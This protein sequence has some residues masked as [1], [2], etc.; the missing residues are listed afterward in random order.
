[1]ATYTVIL[2]RQEAS[3][4]TVQID[5]A[6]SD[7]LLAKV[8]EDYP[9]ASIVSWQ[10]EASEQAAAEKVK[11]AEEAKEAKEAAAGDD[12]DEEEAADED[13][14]GETSSSAHKKAAPPKPVKGR[15]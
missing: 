11:E 12:K 9:S 13:K 8:L 7:A 14:D 2:A 5:A 1:M 6:D 3:D 15:G 4:L 10:I